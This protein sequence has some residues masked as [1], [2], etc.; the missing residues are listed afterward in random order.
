[1]LITFCGLRFSDSC[2]FKDVIP[3]YL[4][5]NFPHLNQ[6]NEYVIDEVRKLYLLQKL[7]YMQTPTIINYN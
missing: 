7:T 6:L 1:L 2:Y 4:F 5:F 3:H